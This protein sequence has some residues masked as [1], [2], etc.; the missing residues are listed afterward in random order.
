MFIYSVDTYFFCRS[1]R[2]QCTFLHAASLC[3][4]DKARR[5]KSGSHGAFARFTCGSARHLNPIGI[6]FFQ[7]FLKFLRIR[8][9]IHLCVIETA[10]ACHFSCYPAN[11][12][13]SG[14]KSTFTFHILLNK[15]GKSA[16]GESL[17]FPSSSLTQA[18]LYDYSNAALRHLAQTLPPCGES[19]HRRFLLKLG[20]V[21][22]CHNL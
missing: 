15:Y 8:S 19:V 20:D 14:L 12:M 11:L 21:N 3:S 1:N 6:Q 17:I 9:R 7:L 4:S 2:E 18:L 10:T 13:N 16:S 22:S 5:C